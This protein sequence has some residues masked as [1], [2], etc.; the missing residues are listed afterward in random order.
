VH[1]QPI[2]L[3]C[4]ANVS[5]KVQGNLERRRQELASVELREKSFDL[6]SSAIMISARAA[7]SKAADELADARTR[8]QLFEAANDA[9]YDQLQASIRCARG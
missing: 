9:A 5:P 7:V 3:S 2:R 4:N 6:S 8:L 1:F